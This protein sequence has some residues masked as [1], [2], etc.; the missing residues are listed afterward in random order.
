MAIAG[1]RR[2]RYA[3]SGVRLELGTD[4]MVASDDWYLERA[5]FWHGAGG[6]AACWAGC[7]AGLVELLRPTWRG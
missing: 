6:V 7:A 5:G 2:H 3:I 1:I 4:D